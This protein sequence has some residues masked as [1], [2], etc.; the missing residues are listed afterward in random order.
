[1]RTTLT[2]LTRHEIDVG[3]RTRR[4]LL[5][6]ILFTASAVLG[7]LAVGAVINKAEQAI[8]TEV[9]DRAGVDELTIRAELTERREEFIG[10]L[11]ARR[12][13]D[14]EELDPSIIGSSLAAV[15]FW[16]ALTLFPFLIL[17]ATYDALAS[18]LRARTLCYATLR[19]PRWTLVVSK[20]LAW[21]A[22]TSAV[23]SVAT[24]V[25]F[26]GASTF[27]ES[28]A[29]AAALWAALRV[30]AGLVPVAATWVGLT[31]ACSASTNGSM[32]ALLRAS[33]LLIAL[34][35]MVLPAALSNAPEGSPQAALV[36][37][38]RALSPSTH[39]GGLWHGFDG[40]L[41]GSVAI[42]LAFGAVG[43]LGAIAI[44]QRRDL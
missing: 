5:V 9:V 30:S 43:V 11:I 6:A 31:L 33:F 22:V 13:V 26:L 10:E 41:V 17:L 15:Y 3:I 19:A 36:R 7:G 16:L 8:V 40:A 23:M 20:A 32:S 39:T 14:I 29:P 2:E 1:M 37:G 44:L 24:L 35:S 34:R 27:M 28:L 21:W 12:G 25:V 18:D 38:L 42:A 4:F